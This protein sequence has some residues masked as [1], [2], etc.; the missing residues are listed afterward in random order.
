LPD[1]LAVLLYPLE[2]PA[3]L[4]AYFDSL[5]GHAPEKLRAIKDDA[6]LERAARFVESL[7]VRSRLALRPEEYPWSSIGW[8]RAA[9]RAS[10]ITP[11]GP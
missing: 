2:D 6:D 4:L 1:R 11:Q 5:T 10:V 8:M 3:A 9:Q 7:P